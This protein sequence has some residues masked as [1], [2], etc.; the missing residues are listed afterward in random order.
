MRQ[1]TRR[2]GARRVQW[3]DAVH[4]FHNLGP[5]IPD[6]PAAWDPGVDGGIR[7]S[8]SGDGRA[9]IRSEQATVARWSRPFWRAMERRRSRSLERVESFSENYFSS[10]SIDSAFFV[11]EFPS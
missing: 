7:R 10:D 9:M 11:S 1:A 3:F 2:A 8:N 6:L 4:S 5:L